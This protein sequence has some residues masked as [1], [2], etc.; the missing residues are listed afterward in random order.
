[1]ERHALPAQQSIEPWCQR[2]PGMLTVF[3]MFNQQSIRWG[4]FSGTAVELLTGDRTG[5]DVDL[6]LHDEDFDRVPPLLPDA[7]VERDKLVKIAC[8]D[9]KQLTYRAD[10]IV[11]VVDGRQLQIMRPLDGVHCGDHRYDM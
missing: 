11:A 2:H 10:E 1:M 5:D 9:Q 8:S 3:D 6:L 7:T 4:I